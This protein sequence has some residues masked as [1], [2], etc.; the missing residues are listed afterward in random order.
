MLD[1]SAYKLVTYNSC[2]GGGPHLSEKG[3][4]LFKTL[5]G[6]QPDTSKSLLELIVVNELGVKAASGQYSEFAFALV[7]KGFRKYIDLNEYNELQYPSVCLNWM[8]MA[9]VERVLE[10]KGI[11]MR[12]EY[13]VIKST[14]IDLMYVEL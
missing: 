8:I 3:K 7:R 10:A 4:Q 9:E 5:R 1:S 14:D 2:H 13:N 12:E 6:N 11:L